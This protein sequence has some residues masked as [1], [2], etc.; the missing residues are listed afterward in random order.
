M[1]LRNAALLLLC[2]PVGLLTP[3]CGGA[4]HFHGSA[5]GEEAQENRE[6]HS[7]GRAAQR[8]VYPAEWEPHEAIWLGFR[9]HEE[10]HDS[11]TIPMLRAL[12]RHVDVR[13]V[14][15]DESL[16]PDGIGF[17]V[18]EGVDT[19]RVRVFLQSPTDI[20]FRDPG[21][22]FLRYGEGLAVADFLYSNYANVHPDSVSPKAIAHERIDE[23][24][25]RRL[26]VPAVPSRVVMEGGSLEV[27]GRGTLILSELTR[28]RNPHLT[29]EQIEE[30]LKR[31]LGQR[32]VIW[33][34][35]GLA[36]DP[37]HLQR[38]T[39]R[40]YG[41]GTGGHVDEF[42]RFVNDTTLLLAWV[43]EAERDTHPIHMINYDRMMENLEILR[44]STD[45]DGRPLRILRVPL[46][47]VQSSPRTMTAD[48]LPRFR[49]HD[50]TLVVGDTIQ[51]VAAASYLNYVVTNGL[52]L[53]PKYWRPG[54][55][56][57]QAEKDEAVRELFASL[58][59]VREVVQIDVLALNYSGGGMHCLTQQQ[60][61]GGRARW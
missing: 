25:A 18:L 35:E 37:Q 28:R 60:P 22:V 2:G 23:D 32:H 48:R 3:G 5:V 46:P 42:V 53:L 51:R 19:S 9:S 6:P 29:A 8:P 44:R 1:R 31:T 27:N 14:V 43:D 38:I 58:F 59:P 39:G 54:M 57:G 30:D 12:T 47:D 11:V 55:S 49:E 17:L 33:L 36:E 15:E 16:I 21:P 20:W 50:P 52:V 61:R 13:L 24:V 34:K 26:G 40:F 56:S 4:R 7:T 45:Q 10:S 41:F